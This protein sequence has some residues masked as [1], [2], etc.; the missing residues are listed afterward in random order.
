[1]SPNGCRLEWFR[2]RGLG[3]LLPPHIPHPGAD[4]ESPHALDDITCAPI[5]SGLVMRKLVDN[6]RVVVAI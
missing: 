6:H 2:T 4:V 3:A 1:M 5:N